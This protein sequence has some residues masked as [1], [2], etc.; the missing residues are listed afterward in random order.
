MDSSLLSQ[1]CPEFALDSE[2]T[3]KPIN[4]NTWADGCAVKDDAFDNELKGSI[5]QNLGN[6][7]CYLEA[8][9]ASNKSAILVDGK[10]IGNTVGSVGDVPLFGKVD[11]L[12]VDG[13]YYYNILYMFAFPSTADDTDVAHFVKVIVSCSSKKIAFAVFGIAGNQGTGSVVSAQRLQYADRQQQHVLVYPCKGGHV[14]LPCPNRFWR[15]GPNGATVQSDGAGAKWNPS[16]VMPLSNVLMQ[17]KGRLA[18]SST[19]K[20]PS[21]QSWWT[22]TLITDADKIWL[23]CLSV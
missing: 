19:A 5:G 8:P 2:E 23:K 9:Q 16:S 6:P 22:G 13:Q 10:E 12:V 17:F 14:P 7:S 4:L 18:K 3:N 21:E 11:T 15:S 20:V 1:Y